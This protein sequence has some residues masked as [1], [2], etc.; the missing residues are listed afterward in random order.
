MFLSYDAACSVILTNKR[1]SIQLSQM[2]QA[3]HVLFFSVWKLFIVASWNWWICF[4]NCWFSFIGCFHKKYKWKCIF[5]KY[6]S[7]FIWPSSVDFKQAWKIL[8]AYIIFQACWKSTD[9]GQINWM[10]YL[11]NIH[12][13]SKNPMKENQQFWKQ[14][15]QFQLATMNNFHTLKNST[16]SDK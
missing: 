12:L 1:C 13:C 7:Q 4:Q 6:F 9:D 15:Y 3:L 16:W 2:F 5:S 8:W 10:K 11:E 14:I